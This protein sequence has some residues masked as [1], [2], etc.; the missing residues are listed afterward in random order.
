MANLESIAMMAG[1][2]G[3]LLVDKPANFS[4]HDVVKAV[5]S[6]F[7]LVKVGHGGT[8]APNATGLLVVLIGNATRLGAGFM[9]DDRRYCA[10][11]RLGRETNTGDREG[12]TVAERP[13]D[14]IDR[15]A[16][17]AVLPELK[18][19]VFQTPPPFSVIKMPMKPSYDVAPADP[20]DRK[21]R[22]VHFYRVAVTDFAPPLVSFDLMC[23]KGASIPAFAIELGR[24]L[25]CG[26]SVETLR[27]TNCG[28]FSADGAIP[29]MELMKLDSI[30]LKSRVLSRIGT[31][32][33]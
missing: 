3:I 32:A 26:A 1:L 21:A 4:S 17:D 13:V 8:L 2:D 20:D 6:H 9:G 10:T 7:N 33:G 24:L 27:R 25:G 19:D 22:L 30:G 14:S 5:K 11:V 23:T 16:L 28:P 31:A 18:G 29:L 15:A 12:A